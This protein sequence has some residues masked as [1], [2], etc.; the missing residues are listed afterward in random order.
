MLFRSSLIF[1]VLISNMI[2][3]LAPLLIHRMGFDPTVMSGPLMATIIDVAGLS[4]YFEIARF[5]LKI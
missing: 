5:I 2:G 4:I 3:T 1:V